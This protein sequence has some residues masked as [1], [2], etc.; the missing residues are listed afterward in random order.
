MKNFVIL[1]LLFVFSIVS[2]KAQST[3]YQ[4]EVSEQYPYGAIN[5]EAPPELADFAPLIGECNCKSIARIDQNTWADT[6]PMTWR[7]K[8]IMNGHAVQDETLKAD[9][10]HSG[11]IRQ[12]I[13]DSARWYV[14]YYS[15]KKPSVRLSIWEGNKT[16][17]GSIVLYKDQK[18]PNGAEGYFRLTFSN[19]T[20]K[21]YNWVGE[22]VDKTETIIYP[23]WRIFCSRE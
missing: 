12:F 2:V 6:I 16:Q 5:P 22:W 10:G 4:Y 15:S 13:A 11:S 14:H 18:A 1:V 3:N 20:T 21:G 7:W 23:T 8:Y 9:G 17:D 19:I